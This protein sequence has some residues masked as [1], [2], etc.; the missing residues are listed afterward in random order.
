[1]CN[2]IYNS[3]RRDFLKGVAVGAGGLAFGSMLIHPKQVFP[4]QTQELPAG[5]VM[6]TPDELVWKPQEVPKGSGITAL[7]GSR[8]KPGPYVDR[9]K[10]PPNFT[11]YPHSH[12]DDRTYT[13]ISGIWYVGYGD[14]L[15]LAKLKA[16]PA[17]S[18]HTEP[19]NV[20][21][22]VITKQEGAI[23]QMTGTGPTGTKFVDPAHDPQKK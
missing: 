22:F 5:A 18:F 14:K 7:I 9:V 2:E 8:S 16:L 19:A 1:M 13:V 21:H 15:D 23:V 3:G 11:H 6:L 10:F 12:P 4:A 17:G 20:N